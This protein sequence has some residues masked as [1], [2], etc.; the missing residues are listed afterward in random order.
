M[1]QRKPTVKQIEVAAYASVQGKSQAAAFQL[2]FPDTKA[3]TD[4]IHCKAS[5]LFSLVKV[6]SRIREI[7]IASLSL[8]DSA[9]IADL[10]E[11]KEGLT[12]IFR[13][14]IEKMEDGS[15][16]DSQR[17]MTAADQ[18]AR[19]END[20]EKDN[21]SSINTIIYNSNVEGRGFGN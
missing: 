3:S 21:E 8:N 9:T 7:E 14:G 16:R 5:K 20:F 4:S 10:T 11:R 6:R 15:L 13:N 1:S 18:L 12:V 2:A 19:Y 17:S